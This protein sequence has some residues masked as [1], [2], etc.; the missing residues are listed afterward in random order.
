MNIFYSFCY[1]IGKELSRMGEGEDGGGMG[2]G[3]EEGNA[4]YKFDN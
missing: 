3:L 2:A 1:I 4:N